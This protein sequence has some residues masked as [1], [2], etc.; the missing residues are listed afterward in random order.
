MSKSRYL[1]D[2]AQSRQKADEKLNALK[3]FVLSLE[4]KQ[5]QDFIDADSQS[6][7]SRSTSIS[8]FD[9]NQK[10]KEKNKFSQAKLRPGRQIT[11]VASVSP[12]NTTSKGNIAFRYS[13]CRSVLHYPSD[14]DESAVPVSAPEESLS[15]HH[16]HAYSGDLSKHGGILKG[17]N[18]MFLMDGRIV[19]PVAAIVIVMSISSNE[20]AFFTGHV[21]DVTA[22]TLHPDRKL[23][24]SA[25]LFSNQCKACRILV[26]DSS[27]VIHGSEFSVASSSIIVE[28]GIRLILGINF[29]SDG[30]FLVALGL[31]DT[32]ILMVFDWETGSILTSMKSGHSD[33]DQMGFNPFLFSSEPNIDP[34]DNFVGSVVDKVKFCY[35]LVSCGGKCIKFWTFKGTLER[36][37]VDVSEIP[38]DK[39]GFKG[40]QLATPRSKQQWKYKYSLE[41]NTPSKIVSS[42]I[43]T[44]FC[45]IYDGKV[46]SRTK[47][48]IFT[49]N[50]R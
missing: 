31:A 10:M 15:L 33:I 14:F 11:N 34:M 9:I 40:R 32:G 7:P 45:T 12:T 28:T 20:Q 50:S 48:R 35:T 24:A 44:C 46:K 26:W 6:I 42:P 16:I 49:G 23:V 17:K 38:S 4:K 3:T 27:N 29:S 1:L 5:S 19:F 37:D 21:E 13:P 18:I 25:E 36:Y 43:F 22:L 30:R 41:G 8:N 2:L 39:N 47:S